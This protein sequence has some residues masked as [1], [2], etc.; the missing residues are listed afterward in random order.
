MDAATTFLW[1]YPQQSKNAEET[2]ETF[3]EWVGTFQ[4]APKSICA[5]MAFSSPDFEQFDRHYNIRPMLT[6]AAT[7]WPN[8][9]AAANQL[10]KQFL[11]DFLSEIDNDPQLITMPPK[12]L[13]RRANN[14]VWRQNSSGTCYG[15]T[16]SGYRYA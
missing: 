16:T 10:F 11:N 4:C 9:A 15:S 12:L 1:G 5:D 3:R 2:I 13:I 7:P 6:G 8:R 14:D